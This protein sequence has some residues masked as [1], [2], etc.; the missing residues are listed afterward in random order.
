[1]GGA[2]EAVGEVSKP[3][4]QG[5]DSCKTCRFF[6]PT[7]DGKGCCHR[8]PPRVVDFRADSPATY[9]ITSEDGWCGEHKA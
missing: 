6:E 5:T 7:Q 3:T 2:A 4:G 1:M 9:P 8:E